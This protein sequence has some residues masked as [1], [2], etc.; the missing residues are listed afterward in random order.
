MI[1]AMGHG[2]KWSLPGRLGIGLL[3]KCVDQ[4][5]APCELE[6]DRLVRL[7]AARTSVTVVYNFIDHQDFRARAKSAIAG[8]EEEF[9]RKL[10]I[11]GGERLLGCLAN[12]QPRKRHDLLLNAFASCEA[13]RGWLLVLAG[14]GTERTPMKELARALGL[15]DRVRFVG[16][17]S[18]SDSA[19]LLSILDASI[20]CSNAETFGY[21][22]VEPLIFGVPVASSR[23]GIAPLLEKERQAKVFAP[24]SLPAVRDAISSL[25]ST[26]PRMQQEQTASSEFVRRNFD[27]DVIARELEPIYAG[28]P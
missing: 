18:S 3:K 5:V 9:R 19:G 14:E 26:S 1:E 11:A 27:V 16:R 15:G 24:D 7:G 25:L 12:F 4:I 23:V 21:S 10:G 2:V 8:S 20:H 6:R 22:I 17:L 28:K 13:A